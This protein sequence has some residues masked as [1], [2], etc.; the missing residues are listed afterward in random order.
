MKKIATLGPKGT[1]SDKATKIFSTQ[2]NEEYEIEY[3]PSIKKVLNAIGNKCDYGV[4]PIENLTEGFVSVVLDFLVSSELKIVSEIMLPIQFSFVGKAANL[5][6]LQHLYVQY[7][8]KGQCADFIDSLENVEIITT[9]SNMESLEKVKESNHADGAIVPS[10]SYSE[11][12]FSQVIESV[13]DYPNNATR[14]LAFTSNATIDNYSSDENYRT[15]LIVIDDNDRAGLL[16]SVIV[17]FARRDINL[18]GI[19]SR[20]T[21]QVFGKYHFFIGFEGH[22]REERVTAALNEIETMNK[23]KVLGSYPKSGI[24][25]E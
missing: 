6:N 25:D 20:P 10:D 23:I 2:L 3:Y 17:S 11:T 24:Q 13:N 4:L 7:V 9:Q 14:F 21:G 15:S 12:E 8:A 1:F 16:E 19:V 5:E 18:T 22:I